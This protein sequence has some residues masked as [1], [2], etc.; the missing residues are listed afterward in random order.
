MLDRL[1]KADSRKRLLTLL[2]RR[3]YIS[4]CTVQLLLRRQAASQRL[5]NLRVR[6]QPL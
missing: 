1:L 2:W 5:R 6:S 3:I 4:Q